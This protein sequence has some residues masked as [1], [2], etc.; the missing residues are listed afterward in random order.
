MSPNFIEQAVLLYWLYWVFQFRKCEAYSH[1]RGINMKVKDVMTK[2]P[3]VS[4]PETDLQR[5]AK[6]MV[7]HNVGLIPIIDNKDT[8]KLVGVISDR[9]ITIR[10]VAEGKN[11]LEM[12]AADV[13]SKPV[14]SVSQEDDIQAAASMMEKHKIR[15]VPVLD[16]QGKV[17][18]I[19]AQADIALKTTDETTANV[20]QEISEP[21][22]GKK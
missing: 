8:M 16:E 5:I 1:E 18:G 15:R 7:D 13:M 10:C 22:R 6:Q 19:V 20:V 21:G 2:K 12:K 4:M 3:A 14:M 11:P 17:C 9:D